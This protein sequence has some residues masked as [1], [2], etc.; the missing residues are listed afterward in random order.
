ME[1]R[2]IM[3]G[4]LDCPMCEGRH[5][6]RDGAVYL[7][8]GRPRAEPPTADLPADVAALAAALLGAPDGPET[9]LLAGAAALL[10]PELADLRPEAALV[11][12]GPLPENRHDRVYPVVPA[13]ST[14]P[15]LLPGRLDGAV[16]AGTQEAW[17]APLSAALAPAAHVVVLDPEPGLSVPDTARITEL[18]SDPRAWVG[19]RA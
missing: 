16:L 2:R 7:E 8:P 3:A 10:G 1:R 12:W 11:T 19:A 15:R 14:A 5:A 17:L 9:L 6:I 18:A 4:R 13:D